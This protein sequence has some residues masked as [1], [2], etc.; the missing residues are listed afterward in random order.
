[1]LTTTTTSTQ[2]PN[3]HESFSIPST[4]DPFKYFKK[5]FITTTNKP[6]T[7]KLQKKNDFN[8]ST[9]KPKTTSTTASPA[10]SHLSTL[11]QHPNSYYDL[12]VIRSTTVSP[13][14]K[15]FTAQNSYKFKDVET[16][17]SKLTSS[18]V[19]TPIANSFSTKTI[20]V[21]TQRTPPVST[22]DYTSPESN[23]SSTRNPIFD[24]YLKRVLLTTKSPYDFGNFREYFK[25]I[26]TM[27]TPTKHSLN[28][29]RANSN[30]ATFIE[31]PQQK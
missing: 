4:E 31:N 25:T 6:T 28:L 16:I 15:L 21:S 2:A 20:I 1:M 12:D 18:T 13:F 26:S 17:Q 27:S 7:T 29:L 10:H 11:S 22:S 14:L 23:T 30:P 3:H 5:F 8:F 19:H 24:V 9:N